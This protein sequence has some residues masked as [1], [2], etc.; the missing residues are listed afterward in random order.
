MVSTLF[1]FVLRLFLNLAKRHCLLKCLAHFIQALVIQVMHTL[2]TFGIQV[3]QL[4]IITPGL[5]YIVAGIS[6]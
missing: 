3:N 5:A 1:R 6:E 4:V 2:G